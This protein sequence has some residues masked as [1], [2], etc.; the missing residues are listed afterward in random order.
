MVGFLSLIN[1]LQPYIL[2]EHLNIPV[3]EE[4][5]LTG[6]I[7]FITESIMIFLGFLVGAFSD[8]TGRNIVFTAGFVALAAGF[9]WSTIPSAT[10][11]SGF[12]WCYWVLVL[13][14]R[15][16]PRRPCLAR[17]PGRSYVVR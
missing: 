15:C 7:S 12:G 4:G 2:I 5:A 1:V 14:A 10:R 9:A 6:I 11:C 16:W 8:R 13:S 17:K 3:G